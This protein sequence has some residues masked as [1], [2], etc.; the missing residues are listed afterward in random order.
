MD[1]TQLL[2]NKFEKVFIHENSLESDVAKRLQNVFPS[3]KIE[4]VNQKPYAN[5]EG[6]LS[7]E[8]F[9]E[10]KRLLYLTEHSGH[11]F[12]RCPGAQP[13][14]ACCNYFVLNLGLQCDMNCS[15]CYLQS[16]INTPV[17]TVYSNLEKAINEL[18]EM[19]TTYP[20][21][22]YRVGTGE[23]ID[24]LSLDP[25]TNYSRRLIE[26]FRDYPHWRLE[27][28]TKSDY[29]DQFLDV[30][31]A[32]NVIASWSIN[33]QEIVE[34]E[35]INTASLERRLAAARKCLDK[36][37]PIAFH[38]DP[39]IYFDGWKEAYKALV[40]EVCAQFS[41]DDLPYISLGALRFQPQQKSM[42]R[43]RFGMKSWVLQS[44]MHLSQDGK[45]RYDQAI[46]KEM[47]DFVL[48][49]FKSH[50]P[51]WKVFLCMET[52]ETW[53]STYDSAPAKVSELKELFKALPQ[54]S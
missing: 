52:P 28:K 2:V 27:F 23:T 47:F 53:I 32:G 18:K 37:F 26:F 38:I 6:A 20:K 46:R 34:R 24:S 31:H 39:M 16:Y 44:E 48:S 41:P 50:N 51:K 1:S 8:Q 29:V 54:I 42:M 35:E 11:F 3:E 5:S 7:A 9:D 12:K 21:H 14:L 40:D 30:E 49:R 25:L 36:G 33:P 22:S 17:L 13:G 10:S 45:M 19:M 43:E 4:I 15:Y